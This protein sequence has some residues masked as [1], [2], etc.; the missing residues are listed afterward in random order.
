M[1]VGVLKDVLTQNPKLADMQFEEGKTEVVQVSPDEIDV[2]FNKMDS[3]IV[4]GD[5]KSALGLISPEE[6]DDS[7]NTCN[8]N[9]SYDEK[10]LHIN[11][12]KNSDTFL[13]KKHNRSGVRSFNEKRDPENL[14]SFLHMAA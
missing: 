12:A 1:K 2:K 6:M 10:D 3:K 14:S 7:F 9:V 5:F 13:M 11:A 4:S 8:G